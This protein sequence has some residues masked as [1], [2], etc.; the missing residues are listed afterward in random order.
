[1]T[2]EAVIMT[3]SSATSTD[4]ISTMKTL[5]F[6][7]FEFEKTMVQASGNRYG[8]KPSALKYLFARFSNTEILAEGGPYGRPLY[9]VGPLE[10]ESVSLNYS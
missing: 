3:T 2:H 6:Q 10:N 9:G 8:L 5:H 7:C 4:K 1:M